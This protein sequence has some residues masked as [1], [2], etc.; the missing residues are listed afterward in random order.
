M[1]PIQLVAVRNTLHESLEI[2]RWVDVNESDMKQIEKEM[3]SLVDRLYL[4]LSKSRKSE[5]L[6]IAVGISSEVLEAPRDEIKKLTNKIHY[7]LY[8]GHCLDPKKLSYFVPEKTIE[9]GELTLKEVK[10]ILSE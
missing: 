8:G 9:E 2:T 5:K 4:K 10:K 6:M 7:A 3:M 1:P